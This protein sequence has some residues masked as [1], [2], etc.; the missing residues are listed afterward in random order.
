MKPSQEFQNFINLMWLKRIWLFS[1]SLSLLLTFLIFSVFFLPSL[2]KKNFSHLVYKKKIQ[3]A[4][5]NSIYVSPMCVFVKEGYI[6]GYVLGNGWGSLSTLYHLLY[7]HELGGNK[8]R[9]I[10]SMSPQPLKPYYPQMN[11]E[12]Q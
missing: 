7:S 10:L 11:L 1:L 5:F 6:Q 4:R 2:K 3:G 9:S 8:Y 12:F